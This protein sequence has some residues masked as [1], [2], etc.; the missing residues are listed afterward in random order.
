MAIIWQVLGGSLVGSA[1]GVIGSEFGKRLFEPRTRLEAQRD[2]SLEI[3]Q[4]LLDKIEDAALSYWNCKF[5]AGSRE[6]VAVEVLIQADIHNLAKEAIDL[7]ENDADALKLC[8]DEIKEIRKLATG[9]EFGDGNPSGDID[10]L[11]KIPV[12]VGQ[13]R[14]GLRRRRHKQ[15][16]AWF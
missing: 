1:L 9:G 5:E 13:L 15:K 12:A 6:I 2:G 11:G 14:R 10:R 16:R 7:F 4:D 3:C 8:D